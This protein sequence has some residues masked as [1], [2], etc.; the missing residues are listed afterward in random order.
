MAT[1]SRVS[2]LPPRRRRRSDRAISSRR[3]RVP[4][5]TSRRATRRAVAALSAP[6]KTARAI[7]GA[8]PP[9]LEPGRLRTA[10]GVPL[11]TRTRSPTCRSDRAGTGIRCA[12][13]R[14]TTA[15]AVTRSPVSGERMGW[16][17][18]ESNGSTASPQK[19]TK[20]CSMRRRERARFV[21]ARR[22]TGV[23]CTSTTAIRQPASEVFFARGATRGS[24]CLRT[25][26]S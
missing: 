11:S 17:I 2:P 20:R 23:I 25:I 1:T 26:R 9:P 24:A 5:V 18:V 22:A 16:P 10:S 12:G 21:D 7:R 8:S 3:S 13:P 6:E 14:R 19:R 4:A 15:S